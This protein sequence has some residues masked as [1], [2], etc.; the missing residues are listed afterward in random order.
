MSDHMAKRDLR[1][2]GAAVPFLVLGGTAIVAGGIVAAVARPTDF[3]EGSWLAAYLVLVGGVALIGLGL[4][5]AMF[6]PRSPGR[7]TL[8]IQL[9]GWVVSSAAVVTGTLVSVPVITAVG[10][11]VLLGVLV[12]FILSVRGSSGTGVV[13]WLYR[14]ILVILV[15]SIPIGL[16][17]AWQR[18]G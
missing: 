16:V 17:L 14:A 4:G 11:V 1:V 13:L 18:H 10:G 3:E 9:A 5:Q 8:T 12:S 15:V 6:A 2:P 7:S